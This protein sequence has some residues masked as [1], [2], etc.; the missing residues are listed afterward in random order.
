MGRKIFVLIEEVTERLPFLKTTYQV[1]KQ[2]VDSLSL[3]DKQV[4]K[5]AVLVDYLKPGIWTIG[6]VTGKIID[7]KNNDEVLVLV[8]TI[9]EGYLGSPDILPPAVIEAPNEAFTNNQSFFTPILGK[10]VTEEAENRQ[11]E[12]ELPSSFI[13]RLLFTLSGNH[14]QEDYEYACG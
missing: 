7:R 1:G 13:D 12:Q 8:C 3:R 11:D 2:L 9:T 14:Y 4:F 6:F 10:M 5:R